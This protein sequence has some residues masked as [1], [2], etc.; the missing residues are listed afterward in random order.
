MSEFYKTGQLAK[1]ANVTERTIRYYDKIG[2]LKPS[3]VSE[4]GYRQYTKEDVFDLQ[5][6]VALRHLGFSIEEIQ[7]IIVQNKD[8]HDS[9]NLQIQLID[10]KITQLQSIRDSLSQVRLSLENETFQWEDIVDLARMYDQDTKIVEQYKNASNLKNRIDL[11]ERFSTN[12]MRWFPWLASHIEFRS[13]YR[14]LEI[15]CGDGKLWDSV[16]I[17]MRHREIFLSDA[18]QGM[19]DEVRKK[20]GQNFNCIVVDCQHIPFKDEYFDGLIANH[21]LFYVKDVK[22]GIQEICRVLRKNGVF[23]ASTYGENHMKEISELCKG[24]DARIELSDQKLYEVFG[25]KNGKTLL[26]SYF[27]DVKQ[28]NYEDALEITEAEPLINYIMSCHGNQNEILSGRYNEFREYLEDI[29]NKEGKIHVS[30][31]AGLFIAKK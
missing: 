12:P 22:Q 15:G 8:L 5:K 30:K 4:N 28:Y 23:Y 6:I 29:L 1:M 21:V 17:D 7:P 27:S 26:Q 18:S 19:V 31:E 13:I 24:F 10:S 9:F 11:H 3:F 16:D 20:R 25:L 14:M 2:L